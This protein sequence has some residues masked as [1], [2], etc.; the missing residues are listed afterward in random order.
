MLLA[1][2][3]RLIAS[4]GKRIEAADGAGCTRV[5]DEATVLKDTSTPRHSRSGS[6]GF[7]RGG[8][9]LPRLG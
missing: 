6:A 9:A 1:K 2:A 4:R 8:L 7:V 5:R 3:L